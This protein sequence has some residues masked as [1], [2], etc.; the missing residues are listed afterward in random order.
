MARVCS[1][2][3]GAQ[4]CQMSRRG[5]DRAGQGVPPDAKVCRPRRRVLAIPKGAICAL[6]TLQYVG[7][8]VSHVR[9]WVKPSKSRARVASHR[10][11][12]T[13]TTQKTCAPAQHCS[14][15]APRP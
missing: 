13:T 15:K 1:G 11:Q 5:D 14:Q 12:G 9:M 8:T 4:A 2:E 6:V 3:A 10:L 7:L